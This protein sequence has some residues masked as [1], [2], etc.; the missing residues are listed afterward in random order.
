MISV[1][2]FRKRK[3]QVNK[4]LLSTINARY[5][6]AS[7]GLRS[8]YA[9]LGEL[10]DHTELLEF[11]LQNRPEEIVEEIIKK[12]PNI[13]AF[14]I[15]IWNIELFLKVIPLLKQTHPEIIII[16][17]GPEISFE[18]EKSPLYEYID[19][20]ICGE[21]EVTLPNTLASIL[22]DKK[23][24]LKVIKE[25]KP[26]L[27]SLN[28]P[29]QYYSDHDIENR[30]L[31]VELSRGCPFGCEFCIS[32]LD[33]KVRQFPVESFLAE[34]ETLWNRGARKFKFIDRTFN[35]KY[36]QCSIVL[37]FFLNKNDS[38][39]LHFEMVPDR[40]PQS[41]RD[42]ILKFPKGSL[43]FEIG[44]QSFNPEVSKSIGRNQDYNAIRE[45]LH[46]L[47]N[48]TTVHV[49]A[50]LIIGLPGEDLESIGKGLDTL[51]SLTDQEIQVGILKRLPGAPIDRHTLKHQIIYSKTAPY[52]IM[53][54]D[55][56][57][58]KLMMKLKRF[59]RYWDLVINSGNFKQTQKILL[60]ESPFTQFL[61]FSNWLYSTTNKTHQ[62]SLERLT[63]FIATY[64]IDELGLEKTEVHNLVELDYMGVEGRKLPKFLNPQY[65][66]GK[67]SQKKQ[68]TD[69][70]KRH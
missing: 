58:Y 31:S 9:N 59:A 65:Q 32:S 70:Q 35:L 47:M 28:Y 42:T 33:S 49:H 57:N 55:T 5:S 18:Y 12:E 34:I 24:I 39:F 56:I 13:V 45:N 30:N 68:G 1:A 51:Y 54:S 27:P 40:L 67:M 46:F 10:K 3:R 43:Q 37:D 61:K 8:L 11:T 69:R 20:I 21:A 23:D 26:D 6:H 14:G 44:I 29:Y 17:G 62:I 63:Q 22:N 60:D 4:I 52:E 66:D 38:Y 19:H 15:Y 48:E 25:I 53:Q 36:D 50:D 16:S 2:Y 7:L 64:M 41:L